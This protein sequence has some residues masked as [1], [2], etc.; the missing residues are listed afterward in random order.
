[1]SS[2]LHTIEGVAPALH[3]R[4]A[5]GLSAAGNGTSWKR[6]SVGS[7]A[8][9]LRMLGWGGG[10]VC[11]ALTGSPALVVAVRAGADRGAPVFTRTQRN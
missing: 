1:M 8:C 2:A 11:R 9:S 5:L 3:A 6:P 10:A 7:I 4:G